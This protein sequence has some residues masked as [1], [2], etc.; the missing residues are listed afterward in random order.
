MQR[1]TLQGQISI[2]NCVKNVHKKQHKTRSVENS[3]PDFVGD[4]H[5]N[6]AARP[7]EITKIEDSCTLC[8]L[9]DVILVIVAHF[10]SFSTSFL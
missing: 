6:G 4:L 1:G 2:V 9:L 5:K 7:V 8:E 3:G 10:A